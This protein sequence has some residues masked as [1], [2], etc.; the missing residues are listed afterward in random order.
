MRV[1]I[2]GGGSIGARHAQNLRS[3]L[4]VEVLVFE[5]VAARARTLEDSGVAVTEEVDGAWGFQPEAVVVASPTQ[6]HAEHVQEALER[7]CD[8][9]CEK[10]LSYTDNA[11]GELEAL[12]RE[13][14]R[15][16]M[17]G[18]NMR[19]HFGPAKVKDLIERGTIGRVLSARIQC[20][21]YLPRWRPGQDYRQSYSA[22]ERH[23]GAI[24][25]CIHELDLAC[26]YFGVGTLRHAYV[27]RAEVLGLA[28]DGLAEILVRHASGVTSSVHLNFVQRDYRR[29]CQIIGE[30]GT[31]AWDLEEGA[32]RVYGE[33]GQLEQRLADPGGRS[34][35]TMYVAEMRHFL[36]CCASRSDTGN[37][38]GFARGV[39]GLA[40]AARAAGHAEG[41]EG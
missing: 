14:K 16:T 1:L 8:V 38:L 4:G 20:G 37:G 23:G 3:H 18:C 2:L 29:G 40:L 26:W 28:T 27:Q 34:L 5:P 21:S 39:L 19:F 22:S 36:G 12:A 35:E 7:G 6:C 15:V 32:V 10:P 33:A 11:L 41:I 13:R 25:D 24:L 9:F 31:L 30:K 17:V